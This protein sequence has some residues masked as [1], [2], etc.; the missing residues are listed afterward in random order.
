MSH[1]KEARLKRPAIRWDS[2]KNLV[3]AQKLLREFAPLLHALPPK[4]KSV[5][6]D[7]NANHTGW[8]SELKYIG[9]QFDLLLDQP[10]FSD[11]EIKEIIAQTNRIVS[12][13]RQLMEAAA[14]E[15]A[16][17]EASRENS[18]KETKET[19]EQKSSTEPP[20]CDPSSHAD[21]TWLDDY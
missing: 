4:W 8:S 14:V 9:G 20:K 2:E 16:H 1:A 7:Y 11:A 13:K 6:D 3:I 15:R 12:E 5:V 10:L 21:G 17:R 18:G 19:G